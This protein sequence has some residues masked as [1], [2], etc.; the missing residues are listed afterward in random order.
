MSVTSVSFASDN[1]SAPL[2]DITEAWLA[3]GCSTSFGNNAS[4]DENCQF[5]SEVSVSSSDLLC[6]SAV[7]SAAYTVVHD[8]TSSSRVANVSLQLVVADI[9]F[10][11]A[12]QDFAQTFSVTF[13]NSPDNAVVSADNGNQVPR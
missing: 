13:A 6:F 11:T 8:Q 10:L 4:R 3:N 1:D 7:K 2:L 12:A 5:T 9:V